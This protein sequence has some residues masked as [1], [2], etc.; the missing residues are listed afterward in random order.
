MMVAADWLDEN[1]H[2]RQALTIRRRLTPLVVAR[3]TAMF[4]GDS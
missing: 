2:W 3:Q 1:G 4:G